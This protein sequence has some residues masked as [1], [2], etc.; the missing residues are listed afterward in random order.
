MEVIIKKVYKVIVYDLCNTKEDLPRNILE[1][2]NVVDRNN[3][4]NYHNIDTNNLTSSV[5]ENDTHLFII[6]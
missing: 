1:F 3:Y 5:Y 4:L 6:E 2:D